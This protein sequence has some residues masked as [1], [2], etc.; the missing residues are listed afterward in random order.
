V[1]EGGSAGAGR[2]DRAIMMARRTFFDSRALRRAS[3]TSPWCDTSSTDRGRLRR[4]R[5][6]GRSASGAVAQASRQARAGGHGHSLLLHPRSQ[7]SAGGARRLRHRSRGDWRQ[8]FCF[9]DLFLGSNNKPTCT[10]QYLSLSFYLSRSA[11]CCRA[12]LRVHLRPAAALLRA[13][14]CQLHAG[15][16]GAR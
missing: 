13:S 12:Q 14:A 7:V 9:S 11:G 16:A 10:D 6:R 8:W 2:G 3:I 4:K 1:E 15:S 5:G